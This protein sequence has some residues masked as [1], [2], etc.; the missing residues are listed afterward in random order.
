MRKAILPVAAFLALAFIQVPVACAQ[1]YVQLLCSNKY[2]GPR[3]YRP[4]RE[5]REICSVNITVRVRDQQNQEN[6]V[7]MEIGNAAP[8]G[9]LF[10]GTVEQFNQLYGS[11]EMTIIGIEGT[12]LVGWPIVVLSYNGGSCVTTSTK[13]EVS[14]AYAYSFPEGGADINTTALR[15]KQ[16]TYVTC[17]AGS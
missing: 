8:N 6:I 15:I 7:P 5:Q 1:D 11:S 9:I 16:K 17:S 12:S 10:A 4:P 14:S 13:A 2:S 3:Q